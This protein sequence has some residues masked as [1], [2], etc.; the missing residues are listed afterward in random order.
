[1][2][3]AEHLSGE[4][5]HRGSVSYLHYAYVSLSTKQHHVR[6]LIR[7][8]VQMRPHFV[9]AHGKQFLFENRDLST[10]TKIVRAR[11]QT[12]RRGS[13]VDVT[14]IILGH[15]AVG[16]RGTLSGQA[17][18]AVVGGRTGG[19][20]LAPFCPCCKSASCQEGRE[21]KPCRKAN[22]HILRMKNIPPWPHNSTNH[23]EQWR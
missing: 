9:C 18:H 21:S 7:Q 16:Q 5:S 14:H 6:G 17:E 19:M 2:Q 8:V 13:K 20:P 15:D 4:A 12:P 23:G 10:K 3:L 22:V 1:M 11:E